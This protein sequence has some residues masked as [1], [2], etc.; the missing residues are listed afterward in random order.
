MVQ[1]YDGALSYMDDQMSALLGALH[2]R[3]LDRN[4]IVIF[5]SDHGEVLGEHGIF[6]HAHNL[7]LPVLHV[8]LVIVHPGQVPP[9]VRVQPPV[10][11]GDLAATIAQLAG[12]DSTERFPGRSLARFWT[13]SAAASATQ[14]LLS[15]VRAVHV[16]VEP[17][18][19]TAKGSMRSTR[20]GDWRYILNGDGREELYDLA[21]DPGELH[22]LATDS[23]SAS[24]LLRLRAAVGGMPATFVANERR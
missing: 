2:A 20:V 21:A 7:Y 22:D 8:P 10:S 4:T 16:T 15:E 5:A 24:V 11:L 14:P 13:D 9:G 18:L 6:G 23:S 3:G 1:R 12:L 17:N 19:P